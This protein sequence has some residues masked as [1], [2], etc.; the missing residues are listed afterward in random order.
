ML[1]KLKGALSLTLLLEAKSHPLTL[2]GV[3]F[4]LW[5][6]LTPRQALVVY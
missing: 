2:R 5:G 3:S 1:L 6:E 4:D